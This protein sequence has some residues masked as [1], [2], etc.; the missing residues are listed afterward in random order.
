MVSIFSVKLSLKV[1]Y[2]CR[3]LAQLAYCYKV[4][5]LTHIEQLAIAE[6]IPKNYLVQILSELRSGGIIT[7]RRG[8]QGGYALVR[9]PDKISLYE[10]IK[11]VDA[12]LLE[13]R[14]TS[15]GQSGAKVANVWEHISVDF[16][17]IVAR[18]TLKSFLPE[19][20]AIMY[21]I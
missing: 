20:R 5:E 16:Q 7:S 4:G 12:E 6:Q 13:A 8:K 9:E 14:F 3:V 1:E 17:K 2:A 15:N 10:I 11:V 18:Y 21:H 19:D